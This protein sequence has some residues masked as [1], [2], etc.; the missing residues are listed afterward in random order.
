MF[1]MILLSTFVFAGDVENP[2]TYTAEE[3]DQKTQNVVLIGESPAPCYLSSKNKDCSRVLIYEDGAEVLHHLL[4]DQRS[5]AVDKFDVNKA[6]SSP[7][8]F[9]GSGE[10]FSL[11][12]LVDP[13]L[14]IQGVKAN[15]KKPT[16]LEI[17]LLV[18]DSRGRS[19]DLVKTL[20][21]K[22]LYKSEP[23]H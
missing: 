9:V 1:V 12:E 22:V 19:L 4:V 23:A 15:F 16:E 10:T 20:E 2:R 18:K 13:S 11:S 3:L 14:Q 6:I 21:S 17:T 7:E 5:S 8:S